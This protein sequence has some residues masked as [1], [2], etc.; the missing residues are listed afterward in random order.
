M[1]HATSSLCGEVAEIQSSD[2]Q[3]IMAGDEADQRPVPQRLDQAH[4]AR[5]KGIFNCRVRTHGRM[6][7][8]ATAKDGPMNSEIKANDLVRFSSENSK[9]F[10]LNFLQ[11]A[12]CEFRF[13]TLME[14][15]SGKPPAAFVT[16]LRKEYPYMEVTNEVTLGLDSTHDMNHAHIFKSQKGNWIISL[17]QN[18]FLIETTTY[19]RH[20]KMREKI[21]QM[22]TAALPI[23]DSDFFTRIGL[24]YINLID[25]GEDPLNGW[26][27]DELTAPLRTR[28]F[29]GVAEFS[30]NM[31]IQAEDGGCLLQHS[32]K[33]NT[34][35]RDGATV[36][37]GY[38]I[39]ID[40][41]RNG[42]AATEAM[43][44]ID[45]MHKQ[46]FNVFDWAIGPRLRERMLR[47]N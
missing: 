6:L 41:F 2:R 8:Y 29:Y 36:P 15:G 37:P 24:R 27:C 10:K 5:D 16:A 28:L 19:S 38:V 46:A 25:V 18:A 33:R 35:A 43:S 44:T 40:A 12:V 21:E 30:G 1:K 17:K 31:L 22:L 32:L 9:R 39:D 34:K 4:R 3:D 47:D 42:V 23:I 45:E 13:P 7:C 11:K 14:L 20:E 26:I